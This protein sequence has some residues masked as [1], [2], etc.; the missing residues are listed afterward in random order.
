ME[1][2]L[3]L[4]L[5]ILGLIVGLIFWIYRLFRL[6]KKGHKRSFAI[7]LI[8]LVVL[9]SYITWELQIFPLSKNVYIKKQC[10]VLTGKSFWSWKE[11]AYDEWGVRGEGYTLDIY[12]LNDEMTQYFKTP[13][14]TFFTT[15]P[16]T[17][18]SS[19][20]WTPTPVKSED[21][22][23]LEFVTPIYGG[24]DGEIVSRQKFIKDIANAP[25]SYY[26]FKEGGSSDF[27]LISPTDRLIIL[28]N[29][30]M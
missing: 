3:I 5:I 23:V 26:S 19:I 6:Y 22:D 16:P 25:G 4:L 30:N 12:K 21:M 7:Q 8:I 28:I 13:D 10:T 14:K 27:Y 11:F 20:R 15:Y 2:Y 18:Y 9:T 24:W 1:I 17:S 29:H